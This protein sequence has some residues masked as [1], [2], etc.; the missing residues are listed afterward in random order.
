MINRVRRAV[1]VEAVA[2]ELWEPSGRIPRSYAAIVGRAAVLYPATRWP[3]ATSEIV[4]LTNRLARMWMARLNAIHTQYPLALVSGD[5]PVQDK[6]RRSALQYCR[7]PFF[8]PASGGRFCR[9]PSFCP[10][11]WGRAVIALWRDVDGRL[12]SS[13]SP[14]RSSIADRGLELYSG[15]ESSGD[16]V[17]RLRD[18]A[19]LQVSLPLELPRVVQM[20]AVADCDALLSAPVCGLTEFLRRRSSGAA[21]SAAGG[22]VRPRRF[23]HAALR[24]AGCLGGLENLALSATPGPNAWDD[25]LWRP[26]IRQLLVVHRD[27]AAAVSD[28][29]LQ[30]LPTHVADFAKVK[31]LIEPTRRKLVYAVA[32]TLRYDASLLLHAPVEVMLMALRARTGLRLTTTFGCLYGGKKR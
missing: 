31:T 3:K 4:A 27:K 22:L 28:A 2:P 29:L 10:H 18:R 21:S 23:D 16:N 12:F 25:F 13:P 11:C 1:K 30:E 15:C 9:N 24:R 26:T 19:L 14:L 7:T 17:V 8:V 6:R 32:D 5:D 20:A